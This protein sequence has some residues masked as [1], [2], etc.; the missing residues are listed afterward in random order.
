MRDVLTNLLEWIFG[1]ADAGTGEGLESAV[2][3]AAPWAS[4]ITLLMLLLGLVF[5]H[6]KILAEER[7]CLR[8]YGDSYQAYMERVPR[9]F[10]FF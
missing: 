1:T 4:W 7:S 10:L 6:R 2:V 3:H 5:T 8:Q 9:Y